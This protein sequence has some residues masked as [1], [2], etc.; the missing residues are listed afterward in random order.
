MKSKKNIVRKYKKYRK[1]KKINVKKYKQKFLTKSKKNNKNNKSNKSRLKERKTKKIIKKGGFNIIED[2][3]YTKKQTRWKKNPEKYELLKPYN[4]DNISN[5]EDLIKKLNENFVNRTFYINGNPKKLDI[6]ANTYSIFPYCNEDLKGP[7]TLDKVNSPFT[8][9]SALFSLFKVFK[10]SFNPVNPVEL[11]GN[12][13][14]EENYNLDNGITSPL[15][16]P[17]K[18]INSIKKQNNN[19]FIVSHSGFMSKLYKYIIDVNKAEKSIQDSEINNDYTNDTYDSY[20]GYYDD[21]LMNMITNE[22]VK[23]I[24]GSLGKKLG[25][26][27]EKEYGVFD[28]LDILQII[29]NENGVI[30]HM[31]IRR[32]INNYKIN[33]EPN[34]TNLSLDGINGKSIFIMRHCLGCHNVTPGIMTKI[35]QATEQYKTGKNLG[36]LDWSM[37]FEDTID[38]MVYVGNDVYNLLELYGGYKSYIFGSSVI[39][40]AMLTS[41][42]MFNVINN[43]NNTGVEKSTTMDEEDIISGLK[44]P[45]DIEI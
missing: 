42:L 36:Y 22:G 1:T 7:A 31:I 26:K 10:S 15:N 44:E 20:N 11:K 18:F 38:E 19:L 45:K 27:K 35:G 8:S 12:Y 29:F 13:K 28:N 39:F 32:F 4:C 6:Y 9:N 3:K 23:V 14:L 2:S 5:K 17:E 34:I 41:I 33:N 21:S 37:C 16:N 24:G 40:R 43:T 30:S 25:L